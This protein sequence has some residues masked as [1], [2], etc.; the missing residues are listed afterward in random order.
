MSARSSATMLG[1]AVAASTVSCGSEKT[2]KRQPGP[3]PAAGSPHMSEGGAVARADDAFGYTS[4]AQKEGPTPPRSSFQPSATRMTPCTAVA[5]PSGPSAVPRKCAVRFVVALAP[6]S[7][8]HTS[9][10]ST[11]GR[12]AAAARASVASTPASAQNVG[13]QSSLDTKPSS[14]LPRKAAGRRPPVTKAGTRTPPSV[15][16]PLPPRSG[17]LFPPS[18]SS[19]AGGAERLPLTYKGPP[20]SEDMTKTMSSKRPR[21]RSA[22]TTRPTWSSR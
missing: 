4:P 20:L 5:V 16:E 9:T 2:L 14:V 3:E 19:S 8:G 18:M 7:I 17:L 22:A 13:Y 10:P 11:G 15:F 6:E 12:P 21:A 1:F